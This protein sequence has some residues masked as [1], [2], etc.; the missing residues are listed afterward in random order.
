MG[1]L[2]S[3]LELYGLVNYSVYVMDMSTFL[4]LQNV[5]RRSTCSMYF[6][7]SLD[8][9]SLESE[10]FWHNSPQISITISC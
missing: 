7:Y 5:D 2:S 1:V 4:Q 8:N 9:H 6:A 10:H 3:K